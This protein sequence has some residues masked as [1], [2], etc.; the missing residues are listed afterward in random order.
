M[1]IT[2]SNNIS[3]VA[4]KDNE[5]KTM[6]DQTNNPT[7]VKE[8]SSNPSSKPVT[9]TQKAYESPFR[10]VK[11]LK[12]LRRENLIPPA[13]NHYVPPT[14]H[15]I[16]D[17]ATW[18]GNSGGGRQGVER[19][20]NA[21][22]IEAFQMKRWTNT[23]K[24][25]DECPTIPSPVWQYL[26]IR[27]G[28]IEQVAFRRCEPETFVTETFTPEAAP[29]KPITLRAKFWYESNSVTIDF[30]DDSISSKSRKDGKP[31]FS[32]TMNHEKSTHG[33]TV[34]NKLRHDAPDSRNWQ[35]FLVKMVEA[36][37]AQRLRAED[38]DYYF[39]FFDGKVWKALWNIH[40]FY[41]I[42]PRDFL[43]HVNLDPFH[44]K[45]EEL[46]DHRGILSF[47]KWAG[48]HRNELA[49]ICGE[50]PKRLAY[51]SSGRG[52]SKIKEA[53]DKYNA[54]EI[55]T[56]DLASIRWANSISRHSWALM[57]SAFGL[58][59]AIEVLGRNTPNPR[60]VR[61]FEL[62]SVAGVPTKYV[63][64]ETAI[65]FNN[66]EKTKLS[67][68]GCVNTEKERGEDWVQT[69]SISISD[70]NEIM[71]DGVESGHKDLRPSSWDAL[72]NRVPEVAQS[73]M[74][75]ALWFALSNHLKYHLDVIS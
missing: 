68:T 71:I 22:K 66:P 74:H 59:P 52:E 42:S 28:V 50:S 10:P 15:Q 45:D 61:T 6:S 34:G 60:K 51:L 41:S 49:F 7:V 36:H 4:V 24:A 56:K 47:M 46:P 37:N 2:T 19:L 11:K 26:L 29:E 72:V 33:N 9:N 35:D 62:A 20:A 65:T 32:F 58:S 38:V 8:F 13:S 75:K 73:Y 5:V 12:F 30:Y 69:F 64:I 27:L 21:A 18:S 25:V 67:I 54:G 55:N 14:A 48:I 31:V 39:S 3:A 53:I 57:L 1:F 43:D 63:K 17:L 16:K 40:D 44:C 23:N 70:N